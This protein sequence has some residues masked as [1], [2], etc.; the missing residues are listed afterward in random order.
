MTDQEY[1]KKRRGF[2]R[3]HA[4]KLLRD[5]ERDTRTKMVWEVPV[6]KVAEYLKFDV[7]YL[8]SMDDAH[9]AIIYPEEKLIGLN[10][11]HHPHRQRFSLGHELGHYLLKHPPEWKLAR[12]EAKTCND[13]ANEFAGEL[14]VP[15]ELLKRA[16]KT[17]KDLPG[18]A[19]LF[20]VSQHVLTIRLVSQNLLMKL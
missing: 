15:L 16:M 5:F 18:L 12:E 14:L 20:N 1:E 7:E 3:N 17:T 13:E 11:N 19:S 8:E 4:R 10:S 9:S 6:I 2:A